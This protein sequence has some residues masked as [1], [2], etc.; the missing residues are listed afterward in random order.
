MIGRRIGRYEVLRE[1]GSGSMATVYLGLDPF[2]KREVAVKIMSPD[3]TADPT[4]E[5]RFRYEAQLIATLDHPAIV[6]VYDFGHHQEQMYIVMRFM[7]G[8]SLSDWLQ[9]GHVPTPVVLPI[10]ARLASVLDT[11]HAQNVIHRDIKPANILFN[12]RGE[13]F[14]SDFGIAKNVA[15]PSGFTATDVILGTVDYMS[16]EQIQSNKDLDGRT[17]VYALGIVLYYM[18]TGTLPFKRETIVGTAMAHLGD[19][20]P[21][22]VDSLPTLGP[23]WDEVFK[24]ALAKERENRYATAGAMADAVREILEAL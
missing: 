12:G 21:S 24:K 19:P 8:G 23:A 20:I 1:L 15:Q 6:P 16:P 14:L 22:V 10:L 3:F 11:I 7:E 9:K 17:D 2:I 4:F 18:L 5:D 13:A